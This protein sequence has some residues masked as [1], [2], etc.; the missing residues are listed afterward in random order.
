MV[1]VLNAKSQQEQNF[2]RLKKLG[3]GETLELYSRNT[4]SC[5]QLSDLLGED[6]IHALAAQVRE[7]FW[8]FRTKVEQTQIRGRIYVLIS[9]RVSAFLALPC[10]N[11]RIC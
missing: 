8:Q 1:M 3:G 7:E 9:G 11:V 4:F 2:S 10:P 6:Q 5:R